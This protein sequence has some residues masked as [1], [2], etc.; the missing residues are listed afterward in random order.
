MSFSSKEYRE[1]IEFLCFFTF[2]WHLTGV[3]FV[4]NFAQRMSA[5]AYEELLF[6]SQ[7]ARALVAAD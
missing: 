3:F 2:F 1:K 6:I 4:A 5:G 7:L